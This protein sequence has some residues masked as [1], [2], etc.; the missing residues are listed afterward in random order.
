[1]PNECEM[2]KILLE[3]LEVLTESFGNG[4]I[5]AIREAYYTARDAVRIAKEIVEC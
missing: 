2:C 5:E 4:D 1:M 3:S